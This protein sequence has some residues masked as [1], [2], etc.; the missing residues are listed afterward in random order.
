MKIVL[1]PDSYKG[2]MSALEV[3][4]VIGR[5]LRA[6][7]EDAD[8]EALP[9]ADGGEGT[10]EAIVA[11][12]SGRIVELTAAGWSGEPIAARIGHIET[13]DG[14]C[15]VMEAAGLFGLPMVRPSERNPLLATTRGLGD[16]MR[17]VLDRGYRR[18]VIGLGGSAT[19]DGGMGML[20]ALG[21]KFWGRDGEELA[22][23]GRDLAELA[24]VDLSGLDKR[25]A[26]CAITIASDVANPLLGE[27][28][29]TRVY[30]PQKGA[31][32]AMVELLEQA[33]CR[34]ADQ[35]EDAAGKRLRDFPGAGAAGGLGFAL[36]LLGGKIVPGAEVLERIVGLRARIARSDW[37]ITG[38]GRSDGQTLFGK[39]PLHVGKLAQS[40]GKPALLIS[41]SLGT[42]WER[43]LPY[44]V[45]CFSTVTSPV[46][47][48]ECLRH[49]EKNLEAAARNAAQLIKYCSR[50]Q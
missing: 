23:F 29:A 26:E 19:N 34:Y 44:F 8:I 9:M 4:A 47:L 42:G 15:A 16:A 22:G 50:R 41:G 3:C 32:A 13:E 11:G 46:S 14:P 12:A 48:E 43:L 18:M 37:I 45:S 36:L 20:S 39:L 31:D 17:Q 24:R 2:S 30:G 5:A 25:L 7:L 35:V 33:M 40:A 10:V 1:A 49:A 21:A 38:E 27:Q 28:G 6:E